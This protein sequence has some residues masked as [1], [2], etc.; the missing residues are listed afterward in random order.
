M[1][2]VKKQNDSALIVSTSGKSP[3]VSTPKNPPADLVI[4]KIQIAASSKPLN[5][6]DPKYSSFKD[7][8][9]DKSESGMNRYVVGNYTSM[10]ECTKHLAAIKK[11]GFKDAF[12]VAY[13]NGKRTP[14]NNVP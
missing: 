12:I 2:E 3:E 8:K 14:L 1:A 11:K 6:K 4:Y 13:K 9:N 5:T 7:I 10:D